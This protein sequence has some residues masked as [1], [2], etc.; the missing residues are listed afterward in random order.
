MEF[1]QNYKHF[2][3][4]KWV[5]K[6]CLWDGNLLS[7]SQW[8]NSSAPSAAYMRQ[9]TVS[10]LVQ[11]M[12]CR[13]FGAKPLPEPMLTYCQLEPCEQ[14]CYN[15]NRNTKLFI[16]ENAFGTVICELAAILSRGR[17]VNART[18]RTRR[19]I[20]VPTDTPEPSSAW[21]SAGT[22]LIIKLVVFSAYFLSWILDSFINLTQLWKDAFSKWPRRSCYYST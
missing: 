19:V 21:P 14:T 9:W 10:A 17:W 1:E 20:T 7:L 13:L 3:W 12:A 15:S 8:V 5:G 2:H 11:A 6:Y 22:V 16:Q 4:R 18:C